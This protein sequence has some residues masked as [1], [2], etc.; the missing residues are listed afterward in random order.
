MKFFSDF[1]RFLLT[2]WLLT[3]FLI[4]SGVCLKVGKDR[5]ITSCF[6]NHETVKFSVEK[7]DF[8]YVTS[9]NYPDNY[10]SDFYLG[11]S[12][13]VEIRGCSTCKVK[14]TLMDVNFPHCP[15]VE[16][17]KHRD[18]CIPGCD[19]IQIHEVDQPYHSKNLR[20]YH[21]AS[22]EE[23]VSISSNVK[24]RHCISNGTGT[25]GKRFRVRFEVIEKVQ[26][27]RGTVSSTMFGG[28]RGEI[29]SPNF[30]DRYALND[31]TFTYILTNLDPYGKIR[32][33]FDD[34]DLA[35]VS[36]LQVY[37]GPRTTSPS[38]VY[39]RHERPVLVSKSS[40]IILVFNTGSSRHRC[41]HPVGW[42]A[43]YQF[44]SSGQW[45]TIPSTNCSKI[46]EHQSGGV[47]N[48][49]YLTPRLPAMF[50]CIWIIRKPAKK[51][52]D[53]ILLRLTEIVFGQG[54]AE[55]PDNSLEIVS[56]TTSQGEL[57]GKFTSTNLTVG[58]WFSPG[59]SLYIRL[60]GA[61]SEEDRLNFIFTAVDNV[62]E[63]GCQRGG[64]Y[65]CKNLWCIDKSLR[66]DGVDHCGDNSD[67]GPDESCKF[68]KIWKLGIRWKLSDSSTKDPCAGNFKCG[69]NKYDCLPMSRVCDRISDCFDDSDE[70]WCAYHSKQTKD[71]GRSSCGRN[72]ATLLNIIG[73][74]ILYLFVTIMKLIRFLMKLSHE[75]V[76]IELKN[77]T[78]VHGTVTGVDVCMNT[79]LKAV[80][81]TIKN[82]DPVQVD[83]LS[84]RGNNIRYYI[85]PDSLPLDT[86]LIDD[87]PKAKQKKGREG[88]MRGG[89]GRGRGG[90]G[91]R[92]RGRG[93]GRR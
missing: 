39:T 60:R 82:K 75:T 5:G 77:G 83:T 37:D 11:H 9:Y 86:L 33:I 79:H 50:D 43:S 66:C 18:L 48:L 4:I 78:Q 69:G 13:N 47:F 64:D 40:T 24:I 76:T 53:G 44:V 61:L 41:C 7:G 51:N 30:P 91:G 31:E 89:R 85:L 19:H 2:G 55:Y 15:S 6:Q 42:K 25:T 38:K 26:Q 63:S 14:L 93:R 3:S 58:Q 46:I 10:T 22:V 80:K 72:A 92:G 70:K 17:S 67:E 62:T 90:R 87:T 65:L 20:N 12:C 84:I 52:P 34:W 21:T 74:F 81:M 45:N 68:E 8:G 56:G 27:I 88:G 29:S 54:W 23:Y 49:D 32:I 57:L 36:T 35:S 71:D 73:L 28:D 1:A 16:K 59:S